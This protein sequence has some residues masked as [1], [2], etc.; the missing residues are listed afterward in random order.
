MG[1]VWP[2]PR[3]SAAGQRINELLRLFAAHGFSITFCSAAQETEYSELPQEIEINRAEIKLNDASFDTWIALQKPNIVV[4]DRFIIEEQFGWR[5]AR[6]APNALRIL[7]TEDLHFLREAR[8][9]SLL[10]NQKEKNDE[11]INPITLREIAAIYRCDLSIVISEVERNILHTHFQIPQQ[12]L[13]TLGFLRNSSSSNPLNQPSYAQRQGFVF[14]GNFMHAPNKD[15][16][17]WIKEKIW[18]FIREKL[19]NADLLVYG[20]YMKKGDLRLNSPDEGFY[21]MGRADEAIETLSNARVLL[22]P[23]RFGAGLKGKCV[24]AMQAGTPSITTTIGAEGFIDSS[25]NWCGFVAD[26]PETIASH[27]I[28]VHENEAIWIEK[29][30]RGFELFNELFASR[31]P[32][33][34][35]MAHINHLLDTLINHR[36]RNFIGAMLQHH[37]MQSTYYM[38]K[39]IE[40]K[41]KTAV[42]R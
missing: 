38:A 17:Y 9:I 1:L 23:L 41:N 7:D 32:A 31:Q 26:K 18:P 6:F 24:D 39:W 3:S 34:D 22:A 25:N 20:A 5:V 14:I 29:Q 10:S 42:S 19:P 37:S 2:E 33:S 35:F 40:E 28:Q 16:V 11:L 27:A 36:N 15:A 12:L 4:F 21:M 8:R 13:Y 30:R